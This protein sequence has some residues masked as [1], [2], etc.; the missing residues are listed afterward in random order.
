MVKKK[1]EQRVE[2]HIK[3][4]DI[5]K[6]IC[7]CSKELYNQSLYYL[8]QC[9]FGNI[10]WFK[11]YELTK[12]FAEFNEPTYRNL[13]SQTNQQIVKMV[14]RDWKSWLDSLKEYKINP[15]KFLGKP[16][17]PKYKKEL[18]VAIF[19]NQQCKLR[20]GFIYFPK[21]L[22]FP[23]IKTKLTRF[24]Q[25][26][27]VPKSN[28]FV[29]EVVYNAKNV[30][31]KKD[32][33]RYLSIDLGVN[34]L[35][36]CVSNIASSFI[37]NG[38]PLKCINQ[39]YNKKKAKLQSQLEKNQYTSKRIDSFTNKRNRKIKDY[40]HKSSNYIINF[41]SIKNINT[42]IIGNNKNWK[43]NLNLGKRNN[44]NFTSIPYATLIKQIKYKA[45]D[46]GITVKITEESYTSKCSA[47][48]LEEIKKQPKY[49]GKR[50]KRGLFK[51]S[52]G[53]LI[54]A[55]VNGALNIGRKVIGDVIIP[56]NKRLVLNPIRINVI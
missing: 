14:F 32:N 34:N 30:E 23:P 19:T 51:D 45:K 9:L 53:R 24:Q 17:M 52:K 25:I 1:K 28:H 46:K 49:L 31:L 11:E 50:V 48:D 3:N 5:Y 56:A 43:Q 54:N 4:D 55:D 22:N 7:I 29:I 27:V 12:L 21:K 40:L 37:I 26:R 36:T 41:C 42:I 44:Q 38:K 2:Q 33:K 39:F 6:D 47:L 15:K 18:S 10:E 13:P 20:N 8:R 16:R 35:A